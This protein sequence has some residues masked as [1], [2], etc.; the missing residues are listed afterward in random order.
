MGEK[1]ASPNRQFHYATQMLNQTYEL[2]MIEHT[3]YVRGEVVR[4]K[5]QVR[6][7]EYRKFL[8]K[9]ADHAFVVGDYEIQHKLI[10]ELELIANSYR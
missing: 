10:K 7:H 5:P 2:R 3:N 1:D 4:N 8:A 6:E 9:C